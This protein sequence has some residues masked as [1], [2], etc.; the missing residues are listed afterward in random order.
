MANQIIIPTSLLQLI[1]S[2]NYIFRGSEKLNLQR[3]QQQQ[4]IKHPPFLPS[5][6]LSIPFYTAT[7]MTSSFP[8]ISLSH[9]PPAPLMISPSYHHF[10]IFSSYPFHSTSFSPTNLESS[11]S[12]LPFFN[13]FFYLI[14]CF[15]I[16]INVNININVYHNSIS[17]CTD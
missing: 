9:P 15:I 16:N 10:S 5:I 12:P 7:L 3:T 2:S 13:Y 6:S 14:F 8:S 4:L 17:E 1:F 11:P